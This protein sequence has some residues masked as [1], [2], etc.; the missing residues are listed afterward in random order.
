VARNLPA[1]AAAEHGTTCPLGLR[2]EPAVSRV[3]ELTGRGGAP[4]VR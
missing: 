4:D 3:T 1:A 2:A